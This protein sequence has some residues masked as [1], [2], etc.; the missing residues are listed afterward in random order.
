ML[1][2][3][4]GWVLVVMGTLYLLKPEALRKRMQK[5]GLKKIR[6]YLFL[7]TALVSMLFIGAAVNLPGIWGAILLILGIIGVIKAFFFLKAKAAEKLLN[8][9]FTMPL[10]ILRAGG[11]LYILLGLSLL[12][13]R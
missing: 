2:T 9:F 6:H 5:Q 11:C 13:R 1:V 10:S 3:I 8:W 4:L 7:L 12:L